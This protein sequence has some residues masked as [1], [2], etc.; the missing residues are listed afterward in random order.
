LLVSE[1]SEKLRSL[2]F[3]GAGNMAGALLRGTVG[4]GLLAPEAVTACDIAP[5]RLQAIRAELGVRVADDPKIVLR[6]ADVVVLAVKPQQIMALMES[7]RGAVEPRHLLISIAA[8]VPLA[9]LASA[10]P[11]ATRM[12]RVMPNTPALVGQGAAGVARGAH[13]TDADLAATLALMEAVGV[14]VEVSEDQID[15]VTA[16]SGSGP[17]Y[18]FRVIEL[19]AE[20]GEEMG[21]SREV[22]MKLTLQTV[23][24]AARLAIESDAAPAELR[25]RVTS[26]GGTTAAALE[27]MESRGMPAIFKDALHRARQRAMELASGG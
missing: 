20:A 1:L 22:A 27:V 23:L 17:A 18:V 3:L 2:G 12:T 6:Q 11:P 26:P 21:L 16:L 4:R 15:A 24:G 9:R 14:A 8:G 13:A 10:L 5:E 7:I 19:M 25:R